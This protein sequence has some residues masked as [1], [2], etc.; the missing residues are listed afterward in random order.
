VTSREMPDISVG[1]HAKM[2]LL[3]RRKSMSSP[4]YLGLK[5]AL[6]W[7]VL[8]GSSTLICTALAS[9]IAL[10]LLDMEG[11]AGLVEEGGALRQNSFRSAAMIATVASSMLLCS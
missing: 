7:M 8:A 6:I 3:H 9:S 2:S 10:K 4:S 1:L 11:M 5:P